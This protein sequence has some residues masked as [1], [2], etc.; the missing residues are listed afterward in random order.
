MAASRPPERVVRRRPRRG[1]I[2][3]PVNA[4]LYRGTW[5]LVALPLLL[6]AFSITRPPPLPRPV[7][8]PAFDVASARFAVGEL[9]GNF[10]DRSPGSKLSPRAAA[11]VG[12]RLSSYGLDTTT[13]TFAA[14]IPGKGRVTLRNVIAVAKGRSS[15]SIVVTAHRDDIG[16]GPGFDDNAS[17]T[18]ALLELARLYGLPAGTGVAARAAEHTVVFVSTDAGSFGGLGAERL[19]TEWPDRRR[20][21][22]VVNLDAIGGAGRPRIELAGDLPRSPA[23]TLVQTAAQRLLEQTGTS[24]ARPSALEQLL[25]LA[26]PFSLYEQAPFVAH[27]IPAITL[28]SA[29]SRPPDPFSDRRVHARSLGAIGAAAQEL[30]GS[31]DQ[32]LE[33]AQGTTSYVF[34]G[35]RL[36]RGWALQIALASMLTPFLVATIDLFA[37]CRR[38]GVALAPA[39]RSLRSRVSFWLFS[40]LLFLALARLGALSSGPARPPNPQ[41]AAAGDWP[42]IPL[43]VLAVLG[44]VAWLV[45]R[46]RLL[47]RRPLATDEELAGHTA[48][49]VGLSV[50]SLL[51]T[52]TNPFAL[53]FI[54]PAAHAWLWLP[55]LGGTRR[56]A[57]LGLLALGL[58]GPLL[59]V[60]S[61]AT[62]FGL[63]FDAPWYL[64]EL[65]AV[66]YVP[67]IVVLVTVA[68]AACGAQLAA[69]AAGRYAPYP[70]RHERRPRG[71]IRETVR[72][73]VV[74]V[75]A[76][77]RAADERRRAVGGG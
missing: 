24:P 34:L 66:G 32:G 29:G 74:A 3:R 8:P 64:A 70:A 2:E 30:L 4:R 69:L 40:A 67:F 38:R 45:A 31:L 12:Q 9:T 16:S 51:V 49:L 22:A 68:W 46:D 18:A 61:F 71:P 63:G 20:I 53:V 52:A 25:D 56:T 43:V 54:L 6:A 73:I 39:F 44:F 50:V 55:Q 42:V 57:R 72:T 14:T 47:P 19:A 41:T 62:R 5:L 13:D 36:V 76:Q 37:R 60:L 27:G 59:L 1:S 15:A 28:T 17:G 23:A 11:W 35:D 65:V 26:F 77:R 7:L 58:V 48:A 10:A 75:R 33:L 21:V